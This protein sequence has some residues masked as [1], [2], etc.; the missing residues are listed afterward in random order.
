M[1]PQLMIGDYLFVAKW[2]YGYSRYSLPV[3]PGQLRRPDPR[4]PARARRHRRL[5]LSRPRERG[6]CEAGDRPARR[7]DRGAR[8]RSVILNGEPVPAP[9]DRRFCDA[10]QPEQPVPRRPA[11]PRA[12]VAGRG[13]QPV[14]AYPALPRDAAGRAQLRRARPDQRTATATIS[15]PI[16]VPEGHAVRDGR[17]S[18]RQPRQ[19][20]RRPSAAASACCRSRMCSAAAL[21][22]FWSTDGSAEWI[23]PWTW[24]TAARWEP[25]R[26]RP[27]DAR[28]SPTGSRQGLGHRPGD[29][30]LFERALTHASHG[31]EQL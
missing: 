26:A 11:A 8:R 4:R 30:A 22:A 21:I 14:C 19:P 27:G 7:H 31:E 9:A 29:L 1:L 13:R 28:R 10:G 5:P 24:F 3:R 16:T 18:R 23:K 12:Q 15:A 2:P 20:L 6:L 17:Q 25:D